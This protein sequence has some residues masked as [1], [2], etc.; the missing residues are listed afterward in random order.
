MTVLLV[1]LE[2][3][4]A[5]I[6]LEKTIVLVGRQA[7]C[8]VAITSSRKVSRRHCV[9]AQV[10]ARIVVRDLGSTNGIFIN[11][12]RIK[13]EGRLRLGDELTIGDVRYRLEQ[14]Q[15]AP[16]GTSRQQPRDFS[17]PSEDVP[18]ALDDDEPGSFTF[19]RSIHPSRSHRQVVKTRL[20]SEEHFP[21]VEFESARL[22]SDS[23][24][25]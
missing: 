14:R 3:G 7:D 10:N 5:N 12:T 16:I 15:K 8:D 2:P 11:G 6:P 19:Q 4:S 13:N 20:S 9:L 18:V 24:S 22:A 21:M 23:L 1:P 25:T 17:P